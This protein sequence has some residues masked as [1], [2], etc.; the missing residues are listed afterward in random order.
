MN[1]VIKIG[2]IDVNYRIDGEGPWLTL[3]HSLACNLEMWDPQRPV[4]SK[5]F[6]ILRFDTRGHGKS[7]VSA[8]PYSLDLLSQ[9]VFELYKKLGIQKSHWVGLSMG[10]MI[11]Q[12]FALQ[13]PEMIASLVLADTTGRKADNA[14]IMWGD[15]AKIAQAQGMQAL[16]DGT[17]NR[18]FTEPFKNNQPAVIEKISQDIKNTSVEGYAGCCHAIAKIDVLDQLHTLT[19]PSLILVGD[20]DQATTPEVGRQIHEHIKGSQFKIIQDAAHIANIEQPEQFNDA[21]LNF[22]LPLIK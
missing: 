15:R 19:C 9:D 2:D 11:G 21:L 22:L 14:E 5:Y 3:S 10:G 6:K 7:G 8:S 16:V 18:W 4:L 17:L 20:Q 13:H 12:V 1:Q